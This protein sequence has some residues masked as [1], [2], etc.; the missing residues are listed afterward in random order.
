MSSP[1]KDQLRV[2]AIASVLTGVAAIVTGGLLHWENQFPKDFV[3]DGQS[4]LQRVTPDLDGRAWGAIG[5]GSACVVA[6]IAMGIVDGV[7]RSRHGN[8]RSSRLTPRL[9]GFGNGLSINGQF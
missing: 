7:K 8:T 5:M 9:L 2:G 6:G 4:G 1:P 3:S